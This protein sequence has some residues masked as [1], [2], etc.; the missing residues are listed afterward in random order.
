MEAGRRSQSDS[1]PAIQEACD[2][3]D[4][5]SIGGRLDSRGLHGAPAADPA[6]VAATPG[7]GAGKLV[8]V[9]VYPETAVIRG[10]D[11]V[12]QL[13]VTGTLAEDDWSTSPPTRFT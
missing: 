12:Q 5:F 10:N 3:T 1:G 7:I 8:S 2:E 4:P 9:S 13:V 6:K 11:K